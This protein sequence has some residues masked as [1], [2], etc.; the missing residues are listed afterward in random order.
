M[1]ALRGKLVSLGA[2]PASAAE[3][4]EEES[5]TNAP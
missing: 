3:K 4:V 2:D 1:D 5:S